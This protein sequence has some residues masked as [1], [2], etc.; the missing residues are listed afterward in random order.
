VLIALYLCSTLLVVVYQYH[1]RRWR[2]AA[3]LAVAALAASIAMTT[4]WPWRFARGELVRPGAWGPGVAVAHDPSWGLTVS[5]V[6]NV[7]RQMGERWRRLNARITVSGI[8]P[9]M[10]VQSIGIRSTLRFRDG[11]VA[12]SGQVGGHWFRFSRTAAE[13]ALGA[14]I[15]A[16]GDFS[17]RADRSTVITLLDR[18]LVSHRGQSGRL[19][20]DIDVRVTQM[21]QAGTLQLTPGTVIDRGTSRLEIAAVQRAPD[22]LNVV[23]RRWRV[24]PAFST[25]PFLEQYFALRRRSSGEALMG[26]VD[27]SWRLGGGGGLIPLPVGSGGFSV[28]SLYVRF[29]GPGFGIPPG[30]DI[31]SFDD[32]EL[33]V[34]EV[35]PAGVVTRRLVLDPFVVPAS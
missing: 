21:R 14:R 34:L 13:A 18:E 26:G 9:Q 3:G 12:E 30:I 33:V 6:F 17:N 28:G 5:D 2:V 4:F 27:N 1:H 7:S 16:T 25:G 22:S 15:L 11:S 29:P 10:M 32:A 24:E 23:I 19:E 8:P 31:G 35:V 20:S